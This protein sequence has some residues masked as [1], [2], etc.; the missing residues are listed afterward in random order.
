VREPAWD[1]V[2]LGDRRVLT[3]DGQP[4]VTRYSERV[5][6]AL[7]ERK[8]IRRTPPYLSYKE[9]AGPLLG[10]CSGISVAGARGLRV[11]EVGCSGHMTEYLVS[12][13]R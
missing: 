12:A 3:V 4:H 6:R 8:G 7:I 2:D 10:R 13:P 5:V 11:L 9:T 1:L